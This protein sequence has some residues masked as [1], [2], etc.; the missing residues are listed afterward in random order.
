MLYTNIQKSGRESIKGN[1]RVAIKENEKEEYGIL[2]TK[3]RKYF[4]ED[5]HLLSSASGNS[6]KVKIGS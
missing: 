1:Q 4:K 5:N 2:E 6:D 3:G